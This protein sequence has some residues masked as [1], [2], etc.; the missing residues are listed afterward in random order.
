MSQVKKGT[1][2]V[3]GKVDLIHVN[4][5]TQQ[6]FDSNNKP[7]KIKSEQ[8]REQDCKFNS[9][10]KIWLSITGETLQYN[11]TILIPKDSKEAKKIKAAVDEEW[12]KGKAAKVIKKNSNYPLKD[13][14]EMADEL[15]AKEKNGEYYRGNYVIKPKSSYK[16]LIVVGRKM[17]KP[18]NESFD[19]DHNGWVGR[20]SVRFD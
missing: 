1:K 20:V 9:V 14:D 5:A 6:Y 19:I 10:K 2:Y 7:V 3:S 11:A 13:G 12:E 18:N 8:A 4:V 15:E 17:V 16:P